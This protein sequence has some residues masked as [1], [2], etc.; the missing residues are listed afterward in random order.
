V[1]GP[2]TCFTG[3]WESPLIRKHVAV[4]SEAVGIVGGPQVRN[5]ATIGCCTGYDSIINAVEKSMN[6]G[7]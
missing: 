3:V 6:E 7:T 2:G 1:I 5:M 4:L